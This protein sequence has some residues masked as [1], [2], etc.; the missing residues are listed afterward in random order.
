MANHNFFDDYSEGAHPA[1]WDAMSQVNN[2]QN[3]SYGNDDLCKL[4]AERIKTRFDTD[5]DIHFVPGGTLTNV[6]CLNAMLRNYEAVVAPETAHLSRFE[7]GGTEALGHKILNVATPDGKLTPQL[8]DKVIDANAWER[9][10][11]PGVVSITQ[12]TELGTV[13]ERDELF[14]LVAH[15]KSREAYAYLDGARLAMGLDGARLQP[16]DIVASGVDLFYLG[17]TKVGG[18]FGEAIV[19]VN[20]KLRPYFRYEMV[21]RGAMLAKG[22]FLGAQFARF[23]DKDDLW[24]ELGK[25]SNANTRRL[26]EGIKDTV[27]LVQ[28]PRTNQLFVNLPDALHAQLSKRWG[29]YEWTPSNGE[30]TQVR[31][32][33]S[34]ATPAEKIDELIADITA[35]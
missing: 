6:L 12:P 34:W 7:A 20:P 18:A 30:S 25:L 21:Q 32:V 14:D 8:V 2:Q 17:G 5:A 35:T 28:A 31:F 16:T 29:Y 3:A 27:E 11:R 33:C 1:I 23:F 10:P 9:H 13:Y 4:A 15:I 22:S 26:A 24:I 19:I